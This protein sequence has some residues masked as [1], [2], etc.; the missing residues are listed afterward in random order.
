L[1][2]IYRQEIL[3]DV[4][5]FTNQPKVKF[6]DTLFLHLDVAPVVKSAAQT[7]R[8]SER[9]A[10]FCA[11]IVMKR[12][13]F[14]QVSDLHDYLTNNLLIACYCGFDVT[15]PLPPPQNRTFPIAV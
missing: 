10:L 3:Q 6:Y 13:G 9:S 5:L 2:V 12:E 11:F 7:G 14:S 4:R 1:T 8:P 15:K